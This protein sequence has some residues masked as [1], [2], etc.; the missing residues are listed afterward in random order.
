[1]EANVMEHLLRELSENVKLSN[2]KM[3]EQKQ[4]ITALNV[5]M[6]MYRETQIKHENKIETLESSA[7]EIAHLKTRLDTMDKR[8]WFVVSLVLAGVVGELLKLVL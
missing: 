8:M 1:M 4:S 2:Q 6:D 3:D 7:S 5:K